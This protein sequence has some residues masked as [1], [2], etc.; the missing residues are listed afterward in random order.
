MKKVLTSLT[1]A[2]VG[3]AAVGTAS[4]YVTTFAEDLQNSSSVPKAVLTNTTAAESSFLGGLTGER[5]ENFEGQSACGAPSICTPKTVELSFTGSEGAALKATLSGG[6]G[7][8]RSVPA[9][10]SE[11]GRYSVPSATSTN[12]WRAEAGTTASADPFKILF[13]TDIAAFGFY[14]VDIG[15]FGGRVTLD[16]LDGSGKVIRSLT[17]PNTDGTIDADGDGNPDTPSDGSVLYFG[18]RAESAAEVFRGIR[19]RT[20]ATAADVFAFDNFTIVDKCQAGLCGGTGVPE[21][22]SLALAGLA[23]LGL[24]ALRRRT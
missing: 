6:G 5:V 24:G 15:D 21:P 7:Y 2:C 1:L 12:F 23:L 20:S 8:V 3:W 16:L 14:G 22:G 10:T 19:F 9:G 11:L 4:A 17:V 18:L 13:D